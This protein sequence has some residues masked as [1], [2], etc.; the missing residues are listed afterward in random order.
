MNSV[1]M[2]PS[3]TTDLGIG[4]MTC[5]ACVSRVERA[6]QKVPGVAQASIN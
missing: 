2:P 1:P 6:L 5:S 3:A 4:G